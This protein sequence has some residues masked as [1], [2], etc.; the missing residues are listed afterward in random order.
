MDLARFRMFSS[1]TVLDA[2][3]GTA[4]SYN[5]KISARFKMKAGLHFNQ[6]FFNY[7]KEDSIRRSSSTLIADAFEGISINGGGNTQTLQAYAQGSYYITERLV[8]NAGVHVLGI[9][10]NQQWGIDPRA[11][12]RYQ[13][14]NQQWGCPCRH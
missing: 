11:S 5:R 12:L 10:L 2:R 13:F 8:A 4:I 6:M 14:N 3:I 9:F 1:T 7:Y